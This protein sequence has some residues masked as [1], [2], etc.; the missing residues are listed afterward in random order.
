MM[1]VRVYMCVMSVYIGE[2]T[3]HAI[4]MK[5]QSFFFRDGRPMVP[6]MAPIIDSKA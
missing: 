4:L 3:L 6:Q 5:Y 1:C 2:T